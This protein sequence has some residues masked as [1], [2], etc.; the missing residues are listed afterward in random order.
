MKQINLLLTFVC[1]IALSQTACKTN[2]EVTD[3]TEEQPA[4]VSN[5]SIADTD[6]CKYELIEG[7]GKI[8]RMNFSNPDNVVIQF[9]F[10]PPKASDLTPI[11]AQAFNVFGVG[12][13]PSKSWC[14]ENGIEQGA[15]LKVNMYQLKE[16]S[17]VEYCKKII[18]S[19]V[20]FEGNGWR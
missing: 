14:E 1:F 5:P 11:Q 3:T 6:D 9:D 10:I 20:D 2:Q 17:D 16:N 8:T 18:F 7:E 19:F 15:T 13:Y 12:R 4:E